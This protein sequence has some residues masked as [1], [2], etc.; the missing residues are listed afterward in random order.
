MKKI[1]GALFFVSCLAASSAMYYYL[2]TEFKAVH[3]HPE[4]QKVTDENLDNCA[5]V[6]YVSSGR[7]SSVLQHP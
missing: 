4:Q 5:G 1:G 3:E 7:D 2:Y 6:F